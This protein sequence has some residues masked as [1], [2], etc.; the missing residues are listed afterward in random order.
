MMDKPGVSRTMSAALRAASV[1][2]ETA[3]PAS[4]FFKAGASFTPSPVQEPV[5]LS[6]LIP[7]VVGEMA[8]RAEKGGVVLVQGISPDLPMLS[9]DPSALRTLLVN[10]VDNALQYT[11]PGGRITISAHATISQPGVVLQVADTG[12]GLTAKDLAHV[13][14]RFYRADKA[15]RRS[16]S[17]AGSGAGL[18]LAIARGIMETHSGTVSAQSLPDQGTTITVRLPA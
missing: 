14:E 13:F 9:A 17:I 8:L 12:S 11:Q 10:L 7:D 4:A 3:T 5:N 2:P 16:T 6:L 1:A 15:R 18:G